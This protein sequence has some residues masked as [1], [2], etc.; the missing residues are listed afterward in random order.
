MAHTTPRT[1]LLRL[2][3]NGNPTRWRVAPP[4]PRPP[5]PSSPSHY[6]RLVPAPRPPWFGSFPE[7]PGPAPCPI[8]CTM[9]YLRFPSAF[10]I[11]AIPRE[12]PAWRTV[13]AAPPRRVLAR[14]EHSIMQSS[15]EGRGQ[16]PPR[17]LARKAPHSYRSLFTRMRKLVG[18]LQKAGGCA[19]GRGVLSFRERG[20]DCSASWS[21]CRNGG[22]SNTWENSGPSTSE[23]RC[24]E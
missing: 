22:D 20:C 4:V 19:G 17:P 8:P 16:R 10:R 6:A 23:G 15:N 11:A 3:L 24:C 12:A 14:V 9:P 21:G 1:G 7:A 2:A 18:C 13:L 5:V